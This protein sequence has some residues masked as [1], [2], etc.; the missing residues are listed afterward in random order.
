MVPKDKIKSL[1][2]D[3]VQPHDEELRRQYFAAGNVQE[4]AG[5]ALARV[6]E[7][8]TSISLLNALANMST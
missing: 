5:N 3:R 7:K 6:M 2:G 4:E 8:G 1:F